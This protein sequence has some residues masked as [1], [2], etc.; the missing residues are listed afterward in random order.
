MVPQS[1]EPPT[2]RV[3]VKFYRIDSEFGSKVYPYASLDCVSLRGDWGLGE[4]A[5]RGIEMR[6][7][8]AVK[9]EIARAVRERGDAHGG[10]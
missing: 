7:G 1:Y 6:V 9:S 4:D 5:V 3:D 2:M 8:E 10:D